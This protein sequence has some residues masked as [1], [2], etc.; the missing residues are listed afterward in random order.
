MCQS[1]GWGAKNKRTAEG[2]DAVGGEEMEE[3]ELLWWVRVE[4]GRWQLLHLQT[5]TV[6][7][8]FWTKV[9]L[10]GGCSTWGKIQERRVLCLPG[11][12]LP[13]GAKT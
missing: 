1:G 10:V 2:K 12:W 13:A 6:G 5:K 8:E 4:G 7:V 3:G 9:F 11:Q